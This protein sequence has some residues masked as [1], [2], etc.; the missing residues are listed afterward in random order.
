M[1][2]SLPGWLRFIFTFLLTAM[3][4]AD[5]WS[6]AQHVDEANNDAP[7]TQPTRLALD[8]ARAEAVRAAV[9]RVAPAIVTIETVGGAQPLPE[10][11]GG[12]GPGPRGGEPSFRVADGPTTGLVW[13]ADGYIITSA[14][15]FVRNPTI[16][17][18][19]LPDDG[20][21]R[22]G[23]RRFVAE[24]VSR[25][26]I[27]RLALLKI[28]ANGLPVPDWTAAGDRLPG[29]TAIAC[30]RGLGEW[31]IGPADDPALRAFPA[32]TV[33]ILSAVGR[34]NDIAVQTD[35]KT[36]PANY[37]G[38]LLD[39][40]GRV[41]GVI[42]PM[43][44]TGGSLAGVEW[45]DSGIGFAITREA[46]E[47]VIDRLKRGNDIEPGKMGVIIED[48]EDG[49]CRVSRVAKSSPAES[50]GIRVGDLVIG[51]DDQTVGD[52]MELMRRL[53]DR[54]AGES[55]RVRVER[56][57]EQSPLDIRLTLARPAE[58]GGFDEPTE[59]P[60]EPAQEP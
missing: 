29:V 52:R 47:R 32:I 57:G 38:P 42:V 3:L 12:P 53:S 23:P 44:M 21:L 28:N 17:T 11:A 59:P 10:F 40:D 30:G 8:R 51:L 19:V 39:L 49:R 13:S 20:D 35:A 60:P 2:S 58:L 16:A 25:D 6:L 7:T 31:S 36:S 24:L 22:G 33:G 4:S 27:R 14:F 1:L 9:A 54:A 45:Y 41:I 18:V 5:T 34:R 46:I 26:Q 15:N 37:G 55:V 56:P 50:A 43:G 48:A